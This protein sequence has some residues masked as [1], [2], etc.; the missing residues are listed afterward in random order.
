M[1]LQCY[2][3]IETLDRAAWHAFDPLPHKSAPASSLHTTCIAAVKIRV[4]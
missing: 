4:V 3:F 1:S 2:K